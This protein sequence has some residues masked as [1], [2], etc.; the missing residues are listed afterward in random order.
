MDSRQGRTQV[1]ILAVILDVLLIFESHEGSSTIQSPCSTLRAYIICSQAPVTA[2]YESRV[3]G[4]DSSIHTKILYRN[5]GSVAVENMQESA[6][7]GRS[8]TIAMVLGSAGR[9][10]HPQ[11]RTEGG[12]AYRRKRFRLHHR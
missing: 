9:K 11:L 3:M 2:T 8:N 6:V 7:F 5:L 4:F 1:N 12:H 10:V